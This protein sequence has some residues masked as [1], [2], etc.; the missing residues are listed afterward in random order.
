[1][2]VHQTAEESLKQDKLLLEGRVSQLDRDLQ[3]AKQEAVQAQEKIA[4]S[5]DSL[6]GV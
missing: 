1:M 6:T 5:L 3:S 4:T 2:K